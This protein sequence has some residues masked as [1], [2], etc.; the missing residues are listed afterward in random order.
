MT[1]L[2]AVIVAIMLI[3]GLLFGEKKVRE[4]VLF[5]KAPSG[6]QRWQDEIKRASAETG[7]P[8][9]YIAAQM[10]QES[11]PPGNEYSVGDGGKS[12]GLMQ[13]KKGAH[14]DVERVY[15]KDLDY[16]NNPYHNIL[17][18]AYYLKLMRSQTSNWNEAL[19][20]YNQGATGRTRPETRPDAI[21]YLEK[22]LTKIDQLT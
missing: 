17:T 16:K 9:K 6:I 5:D 4:S 10:W 1:I 12:Y 3:A 2:G 20:A 18:G 13:I 19:E 7:V 21:A 8:I 11:H 15:K 22:I 14:S